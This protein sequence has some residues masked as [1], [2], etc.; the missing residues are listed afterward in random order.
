MAEPFSATG[1]GTHSEGLVV[2][3]FPSTGSW[4]GNFQRGY[5][6]CDEV[7]AHPDGQHIVVV[8][9][10][11][12]YVVDVEG[13]NLVIHFGRD[14]EHIILVPSNGFVLL[15]NCCEFEALGPTGKVWRSRR[16]SW[17]GMRNVSLA[18][19]IVRGEAYAPWDPEGMWY[20]FEVDVMTDTVSGDSYNGPPM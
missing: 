4:V 18:G 9:G 7:F 12:A 10:G 14:I 19:T 15:G 11:T 16:I 2:R 20:P 1:Q 13:H 6:S 8:A 5:S 17:D 3:F